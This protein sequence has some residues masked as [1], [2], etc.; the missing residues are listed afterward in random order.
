LR[1]HDES[2]HALHFDAH[3]SANNANDFPHVVF[4]RRFAFNV[5]KRGFI[6]LETCTFA[7]LGLALF[8]IK[9]VFQPVFL[10]WS[11]VSQFIEVLDLIR[12]LDPHLYQSSRQHLSAVIPGQQMHSQQDFIEES[13]HHVVQWNERRSCFCIGFAHEC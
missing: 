7:Y 4:C 11:I 13:N 2:V 3:Y 5:V 9:L 8:S 6:L 1:Y 10:L 12:V